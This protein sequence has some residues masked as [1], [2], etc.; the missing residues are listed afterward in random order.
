MSI[1]KEEAGSI[2]ENESTP[3][4]TNEDEIANYTLMTFN[5]EICDSIK[6]FLS[7]G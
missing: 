7:K 2:K 4:Q 3:E 5:D 1:T 6:N